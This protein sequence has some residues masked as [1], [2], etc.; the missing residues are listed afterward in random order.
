MSSIGV[1]GQVGER[2][3]LI[4]YMEHLH[5]K[6]NRCLEQLKMSECCPHFCEQG[7]R[8]PLIVPKIVLAN[9]TSRL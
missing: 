5:S 8:G 3:S 6:F 2:D 9:C 4:N 7:H 1:G